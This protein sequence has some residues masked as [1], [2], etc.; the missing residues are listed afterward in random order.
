MHALLPQFESVCDCPALSAGPQQ[1][2][3]T[4]A[5]VL[6]FLVGSDKCEGTGFADIRPISGFALYVSKILPSS[7]TIGTKFL[8]FASP[9]PCSTYVL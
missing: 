5:L 1:K 4:I 7:V 6:R 2:S 9:H 8:S 3:I